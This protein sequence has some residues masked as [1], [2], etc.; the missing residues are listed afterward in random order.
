MAEVASTLRTLRIGGQVDPAWDLDGADRSWL[1]I[2]AIATLG[3]DPDDAPI[4]DPSN[5][6]HEHPLSVTNTLTLADSNG[7]WST[8]PLKPTAATDPD[9]ALQPGGLSWTISVEVE[10]T[11]NRWE[12]VEVY[13]PVALNGER[14]YAGNNETITVNGETAVDINA[15][16]PVPI[17]TPASSAFTDNVLDILADNPGSLVAA[18]GP[19][20]ALRAVTIGASGVAAYEPTVANL[21]KLAGVTRNSAAT[22]GDE[23][24]VVSAGPVDVAG[25]GLTPGAVYYAAA[26]GVLTATRPSSGVEVVVG[27]AADADTFVVQPGDPIV[28]A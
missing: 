18:A 20:A 16:I 2:R 27:F 8:A 4:V 15:L 3:P 23:V 11:A 21:A 10:R 22:A 5:S 9:Q 26:G 14:D 13:S 12:C 6:A 28:L 24:A 19:L 1:N 25:A 17:T 7:Q